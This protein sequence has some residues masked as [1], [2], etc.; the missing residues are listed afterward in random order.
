MPGVGRPHPAGAL[1]PIERQNVGAKLLVKEGGVEPPPHADRPIPIQRRSGRVTHGVVDT[2][3]RVPGAVDI[4]LDLSESDR[5]LRDR[6]V[7]VEDRVVAVLPALVLKALVR[8]PA[9]FDE[10]VSVPVAMLV[11]P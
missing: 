3:G 9:I 5:P 6:S 11:D 1:F 10:A 8:H 4:G 7:G 2:A